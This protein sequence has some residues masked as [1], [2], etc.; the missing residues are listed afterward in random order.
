ML[1]AETLAKTTLAAQAQELT[2]PHVLLAQAV[3]AV[4]PL[5]VT[6]LQAA[7]ILAETLMVAQ[8]AL[9]ATADLA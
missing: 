7:L 2:H 9:L 5:A 4:V 1:A 3:T 8:A 6:E